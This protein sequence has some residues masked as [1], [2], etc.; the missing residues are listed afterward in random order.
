MD[1]SEFS[2]WRK[3][4][5]ITQEE[6]ADR[7]ARVTRTT[8]QNWES[9]ATPIPQAVETACTTWERR[10]K[11]ENPT[12]GPVTL[13]F[14]DGPMFIDPYGPRRPL[15]MMHQE[16][17]QSNA[18]AIARVV[19]LAGH[20]DFH[21][22]FVIEK[23]GEDLWN[24]IE[25]GRV[26]RGEDSEAP[27][28]VNLLRR[29]AKHVTETSAQYVRSGPKMPSHQEV[30]ARQQR[31]EMLAAEIGGLADAAAHGPVS[32]TDVEKRLS[33]LRELGKFAPDSLVSG[34]A[35]ALTRGMT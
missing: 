31:I 27:T 11:Q 24:A 8:I 15:A 33:S 29:L 10:L 17:Y 21:N 1:A 26:A 12:L 28:L 35:H 32:R 2:A 3:R 22:P 14:A 5:G 19:E 23:S 7:W 34:I 13:I 4:A 18:A 6:L 16:P 20:S 25:L 9:G 30:K